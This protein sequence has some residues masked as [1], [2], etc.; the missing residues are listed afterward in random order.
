M[1]R[2]YVELLALD[3]ATGWACDLANPAHKLTVRAWFEGREI[4]K[5]QANLSRPDLEFLGDSGKFAFRLPYQTLRNIDGLKI[6]ADGPDGPVELPVIQKHQPGHPSSNSEKQNGASLEKLKRLGIPERL[7]GLSVLDLN[8]NDGFFC[9]DALERGAAKVTGID[10]NAEA[11]A[12]A[13]AQNNKI[14]YI[15][16]NWW[17]IPPGK[18]HLIYFLSAMHYEPN[19]KGLLNK[20]ADHLAPN[21]V[22]VLECGI[23]ANSK[24]QA[25]SVS[26]GKD[27]V[28]RYPSKDYLLK[29]L[30]SRYCARFHSPSVMAPGDPCSRAIFHA[31]LKRPFAILLT[32]PPLAGKTAL[33]SLLENNAGI[34]R[35]SVDEW[36]QQIKSSPLH[37]GKEIYRQIRS[38]C[39]PLE[40]NVFFNA[41][42]GLQ[43]RQ[44]AEELFNALPLEAD[45]I[46]IEGYALEIPEI[47]ASLEQSLAQ[48][49]AKVW[50]LSRVV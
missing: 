31:R 24:G 33:A 43:R 35:F 50:R 13:R 37:S 10:A 38:N 11:I 27:G 39:P 17:N 2:G 40:I 36:L 14:H 9:L 6:C 49:G 32:G 28:F 21:G 8:C 3:Y 1:I 12:K 4:A 30:L 5:T 29:S 16:G 25:W 45:C 26:Q 42:N 34:I 47:S 44:F 7:D 23:D 22:L 19:P 15:H 48:A 18:Y 20:I 41:L 46:I